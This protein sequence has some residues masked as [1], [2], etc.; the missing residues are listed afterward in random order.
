MNIVR[1]GGKVKKS[2][3]LIVAWAA[4]LSLA[5]YVLPPLGSRANP[6]PLVTGLFIVVTLLLSTYTLV[7]VFAYLVRS[8]RRVGT[9]P[10]RTEYAAWLSL[11]SV[12]F[13][14][15]LAWV[16]GVAVPVI[17]HRVKSFL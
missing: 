3:L 12:V 14:V 11:Q 10:N 13:L 1:P 16:L 7:E 5:A 8:W 4:L 6:T 17:A 15:I 9:V 2:M